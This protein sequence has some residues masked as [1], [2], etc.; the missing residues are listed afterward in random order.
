[1]SEYDKLRSAVRQLEELR[2]DLA[3]QLQDRDGN[4]RVCD[5]LHQRVSKA[6]SALTAAA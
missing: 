1:M 3:R 6:L 2:A 4:L 5:D